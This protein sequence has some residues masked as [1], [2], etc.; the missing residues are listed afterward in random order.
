MH[1]IT[2]L[3]VGGAERMLVSYLTADRADSGETMIVSLLRGGLFAENLDAAGYRVRD[4][5]MGQVL[6][7][8]ISPFRLAR[9]IK[10]EQPDVI[11]SWMYHADLV[12][13]LGVLLSGRRRKMRFYWGVRCSDMDTSKYH[14]TLRFVIWAC[15]WL[16]WIPNGVIA[17]SY[18]GRR[19][20]QAIGY[21]A[22]NFSV[23]P[24]GVDIERFH[25][26]PELRREFREE[27]DIPDDM[28][29]IAMVA[30]VDPMKDHAKFLTAIENVPGVIGVVAG[31]GTE[32]LPDSPRLRRLGMRQDIERVYAGCDAVVSCSAFGEGFPNVLVEGMAAGLLPVATDVG[33]SALIVDG[34]G[35]VVP[36]SDDA[37]FLEAIRGLVDQGQARL[38]RRGIQARE[39]VAEFYSLDRAVTAFDHIYR[40]PEI[41]EAKEG[42]P[43][44]LLAICSAVVSRLA[45]FGALI[46]AAR[47]LEPVE[48]GAFA[49]MTA[50]SGI[51]NALVSGGGDMWLN[52][53]TASESQRTLQAPV[54]RAS[55]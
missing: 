19:V 8:M 9:L 43:R 6:T 30:R 25:P 50:L 47:F 33:D 18:A 27:L 4:L 37:K 10:Q 3:D 22:R 28:I 20:H 32:N 5:G 31:R 14:Y 24:N 16:S 36:A 42:R 34:V 51:V 26:D 38:L 46:A 52:S 49:V 11:Q 23:I 45:T 35:T 48:F 15:A 41:D 44:P 1:V 13:T 40:Q 53:F 29:A 7:N 2:D 21:R 12:T 55:T 39:R 17:N 54:S